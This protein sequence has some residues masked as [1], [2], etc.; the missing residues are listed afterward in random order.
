MTVRVGDIPAELTAIATPLEGIGKTRACLFTLLIYTQNRERAQYIRSLT[1]N[2]VEHFPC[3]VIFITH[4]HSEEE[5]SLEATAAVMAGAQD[6]ICD[7][8]EVKASGECEKRIPSLILPYLIPDL[9]V[10][11]LWA[12]DPAKTP[13]L[14]S[15]LG[16]LATRLIYDSETT[17]HLA[18]FAKTILQQQEISH[19]GIGDLNWA[20]MENWRELLAVTFHLPEL[21]EQLKNSKT[22]TIVYNAYETKFFCHTQVQAIYL[23][24]WLATRLGWTLLHSNGQTYQYETTTVN[25]I[26]EVHPHL[27]AGTIISVSIQSHSEQLVSFSRYPDQPEKIKII[28]CTPQLCEIPSTFIFTK[29]QRGL[30]LI[31]E[32]RHGS[33]SEHYSDL[34]KLLSQIPIC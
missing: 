25:L 9:P 20:R 16:N 22:L 33:A 12:E 30:S 17:S 3:R 19:C 14:L 7:L 15:S 29:A 24:A 28:F 23:Q 26:P 32:I 2:V 11:L 6:V 8:I 13:S 10:F 1:K 4:D 18:I 31:R 27:S 34:L 21:L 5:G